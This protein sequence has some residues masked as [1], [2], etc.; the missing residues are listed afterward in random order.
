[1]EFSCFFIPLYS[2]LQFTN[3]RTLYSTFVHGI[4]RS[5]FY[6]LLSYLTIAYHG[7]CGLVLYA[8]IIFI[9]YWACYLCLTLMPV[10]YQYMRCSFLLCFNVAHNNPQTE[11]VDSLNQNSSFLHMHSSMVQQHWRCMS[12]LLIGYPSFLPKVPQHLRT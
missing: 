3:K 10:S 1:M 11:F 12:I 8:F 9:K 6:L 2:I 7:L 5:F 4:E